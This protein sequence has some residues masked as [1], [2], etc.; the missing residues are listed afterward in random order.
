MSDH[1]NNRSRLIMDRQ[2]P[3]LRKSLWDLISEI[4][5]EKGVLS[6]VTVIGPSQYANLSLRQELGRSGYVNVRFIV[7]PMLAEML[8]GAAM[9]L[10]ARRP[11][12]PVLESVLVRRILQQ[13]DGPLATVSDHKSTL[14]SVRRSFR[15]LRRLSDTALQKLEDTGGVRREVVKLFRIYRQQTANGWYDQEDLADAAAQAVIAQAAPALPDLGNIV[16]Y[17]PRD[18]SPAQVRLVGALSLAGSC[19]VILGCTGDELADSPVADLADSL[20]PLWDSHD[21]SKPKLDPRYWPLGARGFMWRR[22]P[23]RN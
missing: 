6:P 7:L 18:L 13:A 15:E 2:S 12:T 10:S 11:L 16:F 23:T 17:L 5:Q 19:Q 4:K 14:A 3:A 21:G 8:G 1:S 20:R 22:M 9:A